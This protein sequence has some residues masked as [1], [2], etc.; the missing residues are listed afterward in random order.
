MGRR[1][2]IAAGAV[3]AAL[4]LG[5][6]LYGSRT[7][8]RPAT[9]ADDRSRPDRAAASSGAPVAVAAQ[10]VLAAAGNVR[11][12][13]G[14]VRIGLAT[15]PAA[16][17]GTH[18]EMLARGAQGALPADVS[19]LAVVQRWVSLPTSTLPDGSIQ[20]GPTE[21]PAADRYEIRASSN[22]SL[23]HYA[24]SFTP[25]GAPGRVE[26]VAAS[27][28]R[29]QGRSQPDV[30][31]LLRRVEVPPNPGLW[32]RLTAEQAPPLLAAFSGKPLQVQSGARLAPLPP[33]KVELTV[34]VRGIEAE[35]R[36]VSLAAGR[37]TDVALDDARL[38]NA[39]R[40]SVDLALEFV[41]RGTG[42]PI[43]GLQVSWLGGEGEDTEASDA[44]GL[45]VF[46]E[47]DRRQTHSFR[48]VAPAA[49]ASLPEWPEA[50]TIDVAP[51]QL[52]GTAQLIRRRIELDP[53]RWVIAS[54]VRAPAQA[55]R[56]PYPAYMLQRQAQGRWLDAGAAHFIPTPEGMAVS[57]TGPGQYR[58]VRADSPWRFLYSRPVVVGSG[59]TRVRTTIAPVPGRDT[60][61]L[62]RRGGLP[63]PNSPVAV[64]SPIRGVPPTM[65]R[66]DASG[67][68]SLS[69]ATTPAVL[70]E[71]QGS[72]QQEVVLAAREQS[73]DFALTTRPE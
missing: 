33:T 41:R 37:W 14:T 15:V 63:M 1:G 22:S 70:V 43:E 26:P 62:V 46:P 59:D 38:A 72:G 3:V 48:V 65:L 57:I 36:M 50:Q 25:T 6:A 69:G 18:R 24:A 8:E 10:F 47:L 45:A 16:E 60:R 67:W 56:S 27:G 61:V 53:L 23:H 19:E 39:R 28:I 9:D 54:G 20:V 66:T 4:G 2:W 12:D 29:I 30:A 35:R 5:W 42:S 32:Q 51:E 34:R 44:Q 17:A 13:A 68:L 7:T 58:I 64:I 21:L 52:Q 11:P 40:Q 49:G 71:V 73:V 55:D 31:V